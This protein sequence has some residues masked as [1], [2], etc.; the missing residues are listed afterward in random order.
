VT[1]SAIEA[2]AGPLISD[3]AKDIQSEAVSALEELHAYVE[4]KLAELRTDFP[5]LIAKAPETLHIQSA[6]AYVI[7][8]W[9]VLRRDLESH[10]AAST[11]GTTPAPSQTPLAT[12]GPVNPS[13]PH[14]VGEQVHASVDPTPAPE[15]HSPSA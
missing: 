14:V 10:L 6:L 7:D 15:A 2:I 9:D 3:V 4:N 1:E 12:D 13:T 5:T 11:P 8:T